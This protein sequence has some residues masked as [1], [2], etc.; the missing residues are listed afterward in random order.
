MT[1]RYRC[2]NKSKNHSFNGYHPDLVRQLP[3]KVQAEFP[4]VLTHRSGISKM[5][6]KIM[7]P[8]FQHGIGPHRLSKVLRVLHTERYDELQLQY[9]ANASDEVYKPSIRT[10]VLGLHKD[11]SKFEEFSNFEDKKKYN[12]YVPSAN[13]ISYVY[14]SLIAEVRPM[15]DQLMSFLDGVV[16][17]GDHS[18]KI[19]DHMAK[20]NGVSTFSCLYTL[21]NEY[22]EIRLQVLAH[23]KKM[24]HLAPQFLEMMKTYKKLNMKLPELFYTDNVK[25]DEGFL[26]QVMPSLT[27]NVK[28]IPKLNAEG[29]EIEDDLSSLPLIE[30]P[31]HSEIDILCNERKIN[32]VCTELLNRLQSEEVLFVGFDCEWTNATLV[33]LI[34]ISH[35]YKN[36]LFRVHSFDN[37]TLPSNL[38]DVLVCNKIIK[39]G[40]NIKGDFT[41]ISNAFG[42]QPL[43]S[44]DIGSFCYNR[45]MIDSS[46]MAL[47]RICGKI[48]GLRLPKFSYIRCGNWDAADLNEE[49]TK[50]A[51]LDSY[52][53]LK[54]FDIANSIPLVNQKVSIDT[55]PNTFVAIYSSTSRR[56]IPSA[57]GYLVEP[58]VIDGKIS[59]SRIVK[60]IDVKIPTMILECYNINND[61]VTTLDSF[62]EVPFTIKIHCA[63]LRTASEI[64]Y[65]K[66]KE[67]NDKQCNQNEKSV[68]YGNHIDNAVDDVPSRILKDAFHVMQM[69]K[70]SLKHGM[71]KEFS[72][73]FRDAIFVVD[74]E[75][76]KRLEEYFASNGTDWNTQMVKNPDFIL[77][78]VRRYIP[79][80][81]ELYE[82]VNFLF[83][84]Y[85]KSICVETNKPLFNN[86][87]WEASK[88]VLEEIRLG[89]VSDLK[90]GPLLYTE[91][92]VDKNGLMRYRCSRGTSSVEGSVHMNIIRKFASYNAGPRLTDMVLADYR[93]YH[94]ID[95]RSIYL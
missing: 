20:V 28:P 84:R 79:Q 50:Y 86:D 42:V 59:K 39:I 73:R 92:G 68:D 8:L 46:N 55:A 54:I 66:K 5:L 63:C 23:N 37:N 48:L 33:S 88:R 14:S 38:K 87:A 29:K 95:V 26:K 58:E 19:I 89:H 91:K 75:D 76:K 60:V 49:Q 9:Y 74:P 94:N 93:L 2:L 30:L 69:V 81:K 7:R 57:Y 3:L 44:L 11:P 32:E 24:D 82:S 1:L 15:M 61:P 72:R 36:Y 45:D 62:G 13:Y 22:E 56:Q 52:V 27:Q 70:V 10:S 35:G 47:H 53:S 51:A 18:F 12:G 4:A 83:Q 65:Y 17:K 71:A 85:G 43:G 16:L 77:E 78:R 90:G 31:E 6:A 67:L 40:R 25:G 64:M 80:P 34:Q 21:L 41:R